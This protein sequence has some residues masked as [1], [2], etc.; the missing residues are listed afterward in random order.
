MYGCEIANIFQRVGAREVL[1]GANTY[2]NPVFGLQI[3][4]APGIDGSVIVDSFEK[5]GID[6]EVVTRDLAKH[7]PSNLQA[8]DLYI[9][10]APKPPTWGNNC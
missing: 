4:A 8:P 3:T 9:F 1:L 7:L 10:V 2:L 6:F 5:A